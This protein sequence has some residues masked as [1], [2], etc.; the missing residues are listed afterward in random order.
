MIK[1]M[2]NVVILLVINYYKQVLYD[3]SNQG[4]STVGN[5]LKQISVIFI[6]FNTYYFIYLY[7]IPLFVT[8]YRRL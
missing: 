4:I 8:L 3:I 5:E 6:V 2:N 1:C 7:R